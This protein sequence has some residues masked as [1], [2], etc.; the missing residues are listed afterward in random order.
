[1]RI[2]PLF[3]GIL[4][5]T[6]LPAAA[7]SLT[8]GGGEPALAPAAAAQTAAELP[9]AEQRVRQG[10]VLLN[11]LYETM[12]GIQDEASAQTAVFS[13]K[14]IHEELQNWAQSFATLPPL[15]EA[16]QRTYEE[17]YLPIFKKLNN[18]IRTQGERLA[19]AEYYSSKDLVAALVQLALLNQ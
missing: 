5:L 12:A 16:E 18:R 4:T 11:S 7:Q 15:A 3:C 2:T 13:L 14:K 6:S 1:M 8:M 9:P 19:A 10:L 17:Q